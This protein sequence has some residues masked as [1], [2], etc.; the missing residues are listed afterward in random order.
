MLNN[1]KEAIRDAASQIIESLSKLESTNLN[2]T[3]R[4]ELQK[5][6]QRVVKKN[7]LHIEHTLTSNEEVKE[8]IRNVTDKDDPER[9]Q[10]HDGVK[11][12]IGFLRS[13]TV[14]NP[15]VDVQPRSYQREKVA[16]DKW[17][18]EIIKTIV[19]DK[20]FKIP[21]I[22]IR[23]K[24]GEDGSII[25]YEV[26][27]GQQRLT[28]VFDFMNGDFTLPD[29]ASFGKYSGLNW[30]DMMEE[31]NG[32]AVEEVNNYAL[33]TV[34]YD[35]FTDEDISTL[36]IK[37]LNNT[38][39][40]NVQEK[41]NAVRSRLADF[42]RY[43]SRNGNGSWTNTGFNFHDLFSR[44]TMFK[45][46]DKE[47]T[48]WNY[49]N[50]LGLGRMEGDLWLA[51]LIYLF[52]NGKWQNGVSPSKIADFYE[53]TSQ[54]TGHL[55]GWNFKKKLSIT[56]HSNLE[57]EIKGLLDIGLKFASYAVKHHDK[58]YLKPNFMLFVIL[59][60]YDYK[61]TMR[62]GAVDWDLFSKKMIAVFDKWCES[63]VYE[64]DNNGEAR[65]QYNGTTLLGSFKSLWG[66]FNSNIIKTALEIVK[67]EIILDPDWGFVEICSGKFTKKQI[68]ER[69]RTNGGI[70]DY[71]GESIL[72]EDAVGD[73]DI[74]RAW[75][76]NRGG[77][78]ITENLKITTE[79]HN[80]QKM[81]MSGDL[82]M[83][84]LAM[85]KNGA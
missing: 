37:I 83:Q 74:P 5:L 81:T 21:A 11:L 45:G 16:D 23:L 71:T 70:D 54:E 64:S 3:E 67:S 40:L 13:L 29:D 38:T 44:T 84:K 60:A 52:V 51:S 65:Y 57:T 61:K 7:K 85:N 50:N 28:A 79:Y 20:S 30:S 8:F 2:Y 41:N 26:A 72:L 73:H 33:S 19:I 14:S 27:D 58:S 56:E 1:E 82:Y 32:Y 46:Q 63:K 18:A 55:N 39:S 66:S 47:N 10:S 48:V 53:K 9:K 6:L 43:T 80:L 78:T 49:F 68:E 36:F 24:R 31:E 22:H 34:F 35:N 62:S 15:K 25:G 75:G 59:F 12:S 42:V 4:R 76:V 77:K 69:W 17:K